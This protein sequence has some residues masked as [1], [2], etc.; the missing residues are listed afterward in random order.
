[1][2]ITKEQKYRIVRPFT[3]CQSNTKELIESK[4]KGQYN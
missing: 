4:K 3:M 2:Q 1:M